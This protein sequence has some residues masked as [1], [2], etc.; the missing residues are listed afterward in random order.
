MTPEQVIKHFGGVNNT[1]RALKVAPPSISEWL[2]NGRVPELRQFQIQHMTH[3][4][5]KAKRHAR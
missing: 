1:A 3:G 4:K 2:S 5:L